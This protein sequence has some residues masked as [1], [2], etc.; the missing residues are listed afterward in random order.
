MLNFLL[1]KE[2]TVEDFISLWGEEFDLLKELK[3]T[4]QDKEWH[5][6]GD[7]HIHTDMVLSEVYKIN[8]D[9]VN[10]LNNNEKITLILSALFHDICKP[11]TTKEKEI[12]GKIRV[13]APRHEEHGKNY[14]FYKLNNIVKDYE[15][16]NNI[17]EIIGFHQV[18]KLLVV[19]DEPVGKY[20]KLAR[21]VKLKLIYLLEVADMKGRTCIDKSKQLETLE[22]FKMYAEEENIFNTVELYAKQKEYIYNELK[23]Y[24]EKTKEYVFAEFCRSFE[25]GEIMCPEEEISKSFGYREDFAHLVLTCGISGI[26]K[27]TYLEDNYKGYKK[28]SLDDIREEILGSRTNH[29]E[30]RKVL[31]EAKKRLKVMLAK[32]EKIVW[33]ATNYR[34]DFRKVPL[35]LGFNYGAFNEIILFNDTKKNVINQNKKRKNDVPDIVIDTQIKK[36]EVPNIEECHN[37]NKV[38]KF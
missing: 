34:F 36:F 26:G 29:K 27:S 25:N 20:Y 9:P 23:D 31:D 1:E 19:R 10:N 12:A 32:K 11:F 28:I 6:E 18:P 17:L 5:S 16:F 2:Y 24:P 38:Y 35:G 22:I 15:M 7:V 21:R 8:K 30:E 14:L 3:S 4:K 13:V 37:I 33:D